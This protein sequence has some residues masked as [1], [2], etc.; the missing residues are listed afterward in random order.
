[1]EFTYENQ[2]INT[3]LCCELT[4]LEIDTMGLG[5]ITNNRI[6]G[7][8]PSVYTQVDG[9]KYMRYNVTSRISMRQFFSGQV[10]R[11]RLVNVFAGIAELLI[12]AE[13]YMLD[14]NSVV[15]DMDY[16]FIDVSDCS[17]EAVYVPV[18]AEGSGGREMVM[19]FKN[20]MF[21]A[22][23]DSAEN[24]DYVAEIINFLNQAESFSLPRFSGLLDR[25]RK[26][27]R[28][29]TAVM[30]GMPVQAASPAGQAFV[31]GIQGFGVSG[32]SAA[33]APGGF[34]GASGSQGTPGTGA[35][36]GFPGT[37]VAQ[38]APGAGVPGSLPE[39]SAPQGTSGTFPQASAL[40]GTPVPSMPKASQAESPAPGFRV[41][42]ASPASPAGS[43]AAKGSFAVPGAQQMQIPGGEGMPGMSPREK[44][45]APGQ[46]VDKQMSLFYLLQ[47]YNKENAEIYRAQKEEQKQKEEQRQQTGKPSR[48]DS[49]KQ[50]M[51]S[52]Q[53]PAPM[54]PWSPAAPVPGREQI[55]AASPA[56]IPVPEPQAISSGS[57]FGETEYMMQEDEGGTVLME[58]D[59]GSRNLQPYLIRLKNNERIPLDR[60]VLSIGRNREAV[61]YAIPDN[62]F[63]GHYHCHILLRDGELFIVDDNSKNHTYVNGTEIRS[64]VETKLSHNTIISV[65]NEEFE[66]RLF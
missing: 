45:A 49:K 65:A 63:V 55:P 9:R 26:Q 23:F 58:A 41:P 19:F 6:R 42:K 12:Q 39:A 32:M 56:P 3:Y 50:K 43:A 4:D 36:G 14:V 7:L 10:N 40:P 1:M 30:R 13:E 44:K 27:S 8:V 59:S 24:C 35:S 33:G 53:S 66:V 16:I 48:K 54:P 57:H 18:V 29:G 52:A 22:Q 34:P 11:K 20:I 37:S 61:D 46:A 51:S 38:G 31:P 60:A 47:H 62:H 28:E 25:L 64:N 17:P 15:L 21:S 5:M 2:G